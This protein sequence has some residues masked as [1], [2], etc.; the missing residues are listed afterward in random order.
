MIIFRWSG[1]LQ[2]YDEMYMRVIGTGADLGEGG[3]VRGRAAPPPPPTRLSNTTGILQKK[4]K[5]LWFIDV[6]VKYKTRW[7]IVKG[8]SSKPKKEW[9]IYLRPREISLV[10]ARENDRRCSKHSQRNAYKH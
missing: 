8:F 9:A 1:S 6:E 4:K 10:E 7:R 5:T 3:R 2:I